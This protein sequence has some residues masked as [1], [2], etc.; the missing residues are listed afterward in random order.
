MMNIMQV[1]E[2][3]SV[4]PQIF[5]DEVASIADLGFATIICNR[6]DGEESGQPTVAEIAAVCDA[7]GLTL[8]HVPVSGMPISADAIGEQRRIIDESDGPVLAYCRSGH[9]STVTWQASA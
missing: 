8:H 9:R 3:Y 6:P 7:L 1:T 5:P 2:D 4:S